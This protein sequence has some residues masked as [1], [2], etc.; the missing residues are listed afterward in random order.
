MARGYHI[1]FSD[2]DEDALLFPCKKYNDY[3]HT[4]KFD[5]I[6]FINDENEVKDESFVSNNIDYIRNNEVP[7]CTPFNFDI[8]I[9]KKYTYSGYICS[10]INLP[11]Q[12]NYS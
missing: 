9:N 1:Y 5:Y 8:H 4:N 6:N 10:I 12:T 3:A 2:S 11:N 7:E